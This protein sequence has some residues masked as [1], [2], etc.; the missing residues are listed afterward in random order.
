M[1]SACYSCAWAFC[2]TPNSVN[3]A[4]TDSFTNFWDPTLHIGLPCPAF[5]QGEV[6]VITAT[7]FVDTHVRPVLFWMKM[8]EEEIGKGGSR[9][10]KV[11]DRNW[12]GK[13][14][15]AVAGI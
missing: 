6:L 1:H 11:G 12:K 7:C 14:G 13:I 9:N 3:G 10:G 4:V 5:T 8:Q 2:G 15:K